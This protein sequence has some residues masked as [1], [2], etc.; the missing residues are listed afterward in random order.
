MRIMTFNLRTDF[1]LDINNRWRNRASIVYEVFD[2]YK[3]DIVGVQELNNIMFRDIS[4]NVEGFNIVGKPRTKKISME[5][6]DI[7]VA[8]EHEVIESNTFWL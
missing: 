3:C 7:L 4:R 1:P 8:K 2:K 6:N 5:R